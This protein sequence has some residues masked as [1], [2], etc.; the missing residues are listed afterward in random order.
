M[1][2]CV[3]IMNVDK[4]LLVCAGRKIAVS[5]AR[6]TA[7]MRATESRCVY[8]HCMVTEHYITPTLSDSPALDSRNLQLPVMPLMIN[9]PF[10]ITH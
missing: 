6:V 8:Q 7:L 10:R 2:E 3:E 5:L 9:E 1:S 4:R